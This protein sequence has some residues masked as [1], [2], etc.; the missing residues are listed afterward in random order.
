M[1]HIS[2]SVLA[3]SLRLSPLSLYL[4]PQSILVRRYIP[5]YPPLVIHSL[6]SSLCIFYLTSVSSLPPFRFF[7][8]NFL[9]FPPIRSR[10]PCRTE[11]H[12]NPDNFLPSVSV[13]F[14]APSTLSLSLRLHTFFLSD[15]QAVGPRTKWDLEAEVCVPPPFRLDS[16]TVGINHLHYRAPLPS[17]TLKGGGG[18]EFI[19]SL[20]LFST[21]NCF[22]S[23]IHSCIL[24][25]SPPCHKT[26]CLIKLKCGSNC[27]MS[28][29]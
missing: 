3:I 13:P 29:I 16:V 23:H 22:P 21:L 4:L 2:L 27:Q 19:S 15:S 24:F 26:T 20:I 6:A 14:L 5:H 12:R 9:P 17:H 25:S 1:C 11:L 18:R 8:C 28:Y 10:S 7:S